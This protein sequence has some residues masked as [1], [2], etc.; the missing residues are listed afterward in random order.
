MSLQLPARPSLE[1]LRKQARELLRAL[2]DQ[3]QQVLALFATH[4]STASAPRLA[5]ALHVLA[6]EYGFATW[7]RLKEHVVGAR[8]RADY[9]R[10][11]V[12]LLRNRGNWR[13]ELAACQALDRAGQEG[14][15]A[16]I[17]GMSHPDS[18]VRRGCAGYMDHRGTDACVPELTRLALSDPVPNVRRTAV[19]S[20][21]C[22]RCKP[23]ALS[24]D[25]VGLLVRVALEDANTR[26]RLEAVSGLCWQPPDYRAATALRKIL[27]TETHPDLLKAAHFA[28]K[29]QDPDYRRA[30]D[31][32][33][34]A[35]GLARATSR[36]A[37]R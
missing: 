19:H 12:E 28:L 15:E 1:Q 37:A 34:R 35:K 32:E 25:L 13:V 26:V 2:R 3:D 36:N 20:L 21:T 11:Q 29:H 7:P 6:R 23:C 22:Q 31:E 17:E 27:D 30:Y 10:H 8:Q 14:L 33:A 16:A 4:L 18:L 9:L 24:G 5:D